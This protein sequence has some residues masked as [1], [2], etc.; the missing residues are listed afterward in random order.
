MRTVIKIGDTVVFRPAFG[1]EP[2][3][4]AVVEDMELSEKPRFRYGDPV[5]EV[6]YQQVRDNLVTFSL[7][8]GS[9]CYSDQII[10]GDK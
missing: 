9:W 1:T 10:L 4:K 6:T 8:D 3:K 5:E 7:S 2:P